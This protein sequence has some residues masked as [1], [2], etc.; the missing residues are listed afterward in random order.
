MVNIKQYT[1]IRVAYLT[2]VLTA[3][4]FVFLF[5]FLRV[6][7]QEYIY[8]DSKEIAKEISHSAAVE[9]EKYFHSALMTATSMAQRALIVKKLGGN[10]FQIR[11][12]LKDEL[13][14]NG[15]LLGTW[16]L[17]EPNAFDGKDYSYRVDTLHNDQGFLGISYFRFNNQIRYEIM[18]ENDFEGAYYL[19]SKESQKEQI[20]E[21]FHWR[22]RGYNRL[23]FGTSI[24]VPLIENS[25]FLGTIGID[26][27]FDN[28][29]K[30]LNTVRPYNSGFLLLITSKGT[31]ASHID[32][33]FINK[34]F[35][36]LIDKKE[37]AKYNLIQQGKEFTVETVSE[38]TGNRV[39]RFFYPIKVGGGKPWNIMVEIPIKET[40][41]RSEQLNIVASIILILGLGL[42][43]FLIFNIFDRR[44]Y[45]K[46]LIESNELF[47][48]LSLMSPVG[49]FR[50]N[51]DGYTTYVNPKWSELSGLTL[52]EAQGDG[53][54]KAV[55]PDD[56]EE[57]RSGWSK[58]DRKNYAE[59][60]FLKSDGTVTWVLGNVLPEVIEGKLKGYIGT[61]TN[62]TEPKMAE[63]ALQESEEKYRTLTE[64]INEVIIVADN[65]H[66][67]KY[68][69]KKFTEKLGYTPEEIIGKVGYKILHDPE[70]FALIES[71]NKTRIN[72]GKS[73]Y[74]LVFIAKDGRKIDFI[75]SGAPIL[76]A[77]GNTVASVGAMVDITEWKKAQKALEQSEKKFRDM[78][79]LLPLSVW[80]ADLLGKFT[81]TNNLGLQI[82]GYNHDD[83]HK[84][85]SFQSLIVPEERDKALE[86]IQKRLKGE[87][88][89]GE[90]YTA[91]RKDGSKFPVKIFTS[92][93]HENSKPIGI[94]GVTVD[95]SEMKKAEKDIRESEA[96]YRAIIEAFPD[97]IMVSDLNSN[98]LFGNETLERITGISPADYS[99]P[100][101]KAHIHPDDIH[102]VK[103]A[104]R[105]LLSS[106]KSHT[107]IIENRF[108]DTWGKMH[109]FSGIISKLSID[110]KTLL[111]TIS[112]DITDK[113]FNEEELEKYRNHLELLVK[114]RTEE[115]AAANEELRANNELL[116][117]Q[118]EELEVT[119]SK[120][121]EAQK[122]LV[123][124]EKMASLGILAAGVAHEINNPLNFIYG[125]IVGL[126]KYLT[127]NLNTHL[128][129]VSPLIDG[130]Y[131]GVKRASN[132]VTSLNRYSR[133]DDFLVT[134]C[135]IHSI[136]NSCLVILQNQIKNRI[137]VTKSF[138][139][140]P[141]SIRCM[142]SKLHQAL[143]NILSNS[144]Q[145]IEDEGKI[146]IS[147]D[148]IDNKLYIWVEDSGCGISE[149]N[150]NK[151][152]D[153][154][155]TT[156]DPGKGTGLGLSIAYS[157]LCEHNGS[158]EFESS[159]GVGTKTIISL[160]LNN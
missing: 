99:N 147:T 89:I 141:F 24:S 142:E 137:E 117:S 52:S 71:A 38:F 125:S 4:F 92:V 77:S 35:F 73:Q 111:Q 15:N 53:W 149:E 46:A 81:Y 72:K 146:S 39:F 129:E 82:L 88:S 47:K 85:I 3:V 30:N 152:T 80:E 153:P 83:F 25:K 57:V 131:E 123:Q 54:L 122:Q 37:A 90:E 155:F 63:L 156:K 48:T 126:E 8:E 97:I 136:I 150:I 18:T 58:K 130:I 42:I 127:E 70:D 100:N 43:L 2:A 143:L 121:K 50:T 110:G 135:D 87:P 68:V 133:R 139:S 105:D 45:E 107:A 101:R 13:Q 114:E 22:Y 67:V 7:F 145:A 157:I 41:L 159:L 93:I 95:I 59:Y 158:L 11:E 12:I 55:H 119:L 75:V 91:V 140:Q 31:F 44:K 96:R 94:R 112:R 51:A 21:P 60:R 49:I 116:Y 32:S 64:S 106:N 128:T 19:L 109:W 66:I 65:N 34:N 40:T 62:I 14:N 120:L 115:L 138:T 160:P 103:D 29:R 151:I 6:N 26:I 61:I 124:S 10:R 113:K 98:I 144:I 104:I 28:L 16:T 76:D 5:F 74:E 36:D 20:V 148:I 134:K 69:N 132:I 78:A 33:T 1:S 86:N 79:N 17:W 102:L 154:F 56:R 118:R 9:T 108:I 27:D 84:G 23:F